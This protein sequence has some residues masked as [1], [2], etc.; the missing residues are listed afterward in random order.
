MLKFQINRLKKITTPYRNLPSMAAFLSFAEDIRAFCGFM[1]TWDLRV[2]V[3][4]FSI[5][6]DENMD[7]RYVFELNF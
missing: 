1:A 3:L 4:W 6:S 7:C 5:R 2:E